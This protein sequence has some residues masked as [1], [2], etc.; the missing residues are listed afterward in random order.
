MIRYREEDRIPTVS[1]F[2]CLKSII[3]QFQRG[4]VF[5]LKEA[6]LIKKAR[7][8][9]YLAWL[10]SDKLYVKKYDET[11]AETVQTELFCFGDKI[12]EASYAD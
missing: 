8:Y 1:M 10:G 5:S 11:L 2:Q 4:L 6:K 9:Q 3:Q 12:L 7:F